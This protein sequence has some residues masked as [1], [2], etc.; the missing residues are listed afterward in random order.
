MMEIVL[1]ISLPRIKEMMNVLHSLLHRI[2]LIVKGKDD[3]DAA[4]SE[5]N[6]EGSATSG[7]LND[8]MGAQPARTIVGISSVSNSF[9]KFD[10]WTHSFQS[11][12]YREIG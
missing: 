6:S 4:A 11:C 9:T 5:S 8:E 2:D 12:V 10:S 1:A 3:D 7:A